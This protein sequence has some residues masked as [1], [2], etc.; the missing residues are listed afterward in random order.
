VEGGEKEEMKKVILVM[1]LAVFMLSAM[2]VPSL[3]QDVT[4]GVSVGDWFMYEGDLVL[5]E[6]DDGVPFPPHQMY[7]FLQTW[8]ESD[9]QKRTVTNVSGTTVTYEIVTHYKNG[10]EV[11]QTVDEGVTSAFTYYA[12][13]ANLG[14]GDQARASIFG[15]PMILNETI[16]REYG[17]ITR[18]TNYC[19]WSS[20]YSNPLP[21]LYDVY[22]HDDFYWDKATGILAEWVYN[23]S[24]SMAEGNATYS[25][26]QKLIDANVWVIPEFPTGTVML[27][28]FVAVT[29]CVDIYRR[30]K[31][32]PRIG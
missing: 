21:T 31:L 3:S 15:D 30:K 27:L 32:K 4:V 14:P 22:T 9:W 6:A 11:T 8:N 26:I 17:D 20:F 16:D 7:S 19:E 12:I 23:G 10:T 24:L 29:V 2:A 5:W 1:L 28:V 13:G 25:V 18:E